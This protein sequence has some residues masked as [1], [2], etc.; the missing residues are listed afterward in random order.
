VVTLNTIAST[1]V[2]PDPRTSII[3]VAGLYTAGSE[4]PSDI[5]VSRVSLSVAT[6]RLSK[7]HLASIIE[8][9]STRIPEIRVSSLV[10]RWST[11]ARM[12]WR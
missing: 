1:G 6:P 7:Q 9:I 12:C 11:L 2:R 5:V 10:A 4:K 8:T 3:E